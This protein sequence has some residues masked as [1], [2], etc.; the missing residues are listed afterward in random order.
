MQINI[1]VLLQKVFNKESLKVYEE[2]RFCALNWK[3]SV[4]IN[5]SVLLHSLKV[6]NKESLTSLKVYEE[7]KFC[8]L[9]W[10]KSVP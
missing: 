5:I 7:I 10:K 9:N 1:S 8:A 2:I 6:L 4:Q 3:K